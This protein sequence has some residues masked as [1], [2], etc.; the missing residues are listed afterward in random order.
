MPRKKGSQAAYKR[1]PILIAT[2]VSHADRALIE[3]AA[4]AANMPV[5]SMLRDIIMPEVRR[6]VHEAAAEAG[7]V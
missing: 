5:A 4:I 3:A 7:V 1:W 2:R 6:R